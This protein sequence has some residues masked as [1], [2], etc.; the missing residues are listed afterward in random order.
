MPSLF[1]RQRP[2]DT[3][4]GK[5]PAPSRRR[6]LPPPSRL[7]RERRALLRYREERIHELGGLMLEMYR[8]DDLRQDVL[9]ER[10]AAI[11]ALEDRVREVDRLL[12][13]RTSRARSGLRCGRCGTPLHSGARFCPSCGQALQAS[14]PT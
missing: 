1:K 6:Y 4:D 5:P 10:A 9:Q 8:Q 13:A 3:A 2:A 7:R 12:A 14:A 11:V